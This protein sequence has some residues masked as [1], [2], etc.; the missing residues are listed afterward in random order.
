[1][2]TKPTPIQVAAGGKATATEWNNQAPYS[3]WR[4]LDVIKPVCML[5]QTVA[6]T[7][8]TGTTAP[9]TFDTED[10]DTDNQHSTSSLTSRVVIGNTLG[11]YRASGHVHFA[12]GTTATR[13]GTGLYF[14][15]A[16]KA[17]AQS[18]GWCASAANAGNAVLTVV[19]VQAIL[20]TDYIEL[21]G[22]QDTGGNLLT[23]V[24]S[25]YQSAFMV[26]YLGTLQ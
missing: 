10:I 15:G 20:S 4:F 19:Y 22:Y 18:L 2:A 12:A 3:M 14:N 1:M 24:A 16:L 23:S 25:P 17:G 8:T 9:I 26:E 7:L 13:R 11:W 5:R 6:Q 21:A